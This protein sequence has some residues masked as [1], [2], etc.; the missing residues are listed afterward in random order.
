MTYVPFSSNALY[1]W[2]LQIPPTTPILE[3]PPALTGLLDSIVLTHLPTW[4]DGQQLFQ[5]L[6]T[7]EERERERERERG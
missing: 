5:V 2:K 6:L 4:V 3:R 7:T 1:V